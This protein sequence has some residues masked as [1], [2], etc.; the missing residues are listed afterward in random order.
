MT[1]LYELSNNVIGLRAMLDDE[2]IDEETFLDTLESIEGE[3]ETKAENLLKFERE[4]LADVSAVDAEIARLTKI[5]T[6]RTNRAK[7]LR[8]Y[9]RFNME[10]SGINKIA[11]PYF[12]ITLAKA[13]DVAVI[14]TP[15][16]IPPRYWDKVPATRKLVKK[17]VLDDL[18]AGKKV[19]GAS[20]GKAKRTLLVK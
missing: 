6:V 10:K 5:K 16:L 17:R 8:E 7:A 14:E 4:I 12:S 3:L 11:C 2:S 1:K 18:K 15:E 19:V 20:L 9:L 13:R